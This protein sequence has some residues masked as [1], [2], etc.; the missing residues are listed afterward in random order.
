MAS[1]YPEEARD[2]W[3][4]YLTHANLLALVKRVI[5]QHPDSRVFPANLDQVLEGA[6]TARAAA[7]AENADR[8]AKR[9]EIIQKSNE[10]AEAARQERIRAQRQQQADEEAEAARLAEA[11]IDRGKQDE[12]AR[13]PRRK[14]ADVL[15][16]ISDDGSDSGEDDEFVMQDEVVD[17]DKPFEQLGASA[18]RKPGRRPRGS[19]NGSISQSMSMEPM[20]DLANI[21]TSS[22]G[23]DNMSSGYPTPI[24]NANMAKGDMPSY[25]EMLVAACT[26]IGDPQGTRPGALYQWMAQ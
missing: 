3:L 25:E 16:A 24:M 11:E 23:F 7:E 12:I 2:E 22:A 20:Q 18:G 4:S 15:D 5:S 19:R 26:A 21:S 1:E 13:T 8:R 17:E 6:R 9:L 14:A 10:E